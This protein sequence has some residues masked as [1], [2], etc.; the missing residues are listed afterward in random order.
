VR[1]DTREQKKFS[2]AAL[3]D[4]IDCFTVVKASDEDV[5][6]LFENELL[7]PEN[8]AR[9]FTEWGAYVGIVTMGPQGSLVASQGTLQRVPA[10]DADVLDVTGAG[11][12]YIAAFLVEFLRERDPW[13][14]ARFA[15]AVAKYVIERTGGV[16]PERMPTEGQARA[17]AQVRT[18]C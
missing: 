5:R 17:L 7:A 15:A 16:L 4:L 3:V 8:A 10:M 1:R 14:S 18:A 11:D 13:A 2:Q 9:R 6:L 12:C